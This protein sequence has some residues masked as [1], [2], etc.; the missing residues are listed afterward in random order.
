VLVLSLD[1]TTPAGSAAL[2]EDG[3][4]RAELTGDP[5]LTHGQRL[6]TDLMRVLEQGGASLPDVDLLAVAAGP[7]S[8]TGL[9]VGIATIQ[10]L[11]AATNLRIVPVCALD[12]LARAGADQ[13]GGRHPSREGAAHLVAAWMDAQRGQV[14]AALYAADGASLLIGPSSMPPEET[15]D[16]WTRHSFEGTVRFIGDGAVRYREI[17]QRRMGTAA[18]VVPEVPPLAGVIGRMAAERADAAIGPHAVVPIY[19]RRPDAEI[20]RLEQSAEE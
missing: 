12:A 15:L 8:F 1:T 11:A 9:R 7:G 6:P 5:S 13:Q 17:I 3:T 10:G 18:V 14:F 20:A 2:V 4:V 16:E 19:V